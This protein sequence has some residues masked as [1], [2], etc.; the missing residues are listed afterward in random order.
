[1]IVL[2]CITTK[3]LS[4]IWKLGRMS[5]CTQTMLYLYTCT[6]SQ[7]GLLG[8]VKTHYSINL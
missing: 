8:I 7:E 4:K 1:M 6:A 5:T 3:L 2:K